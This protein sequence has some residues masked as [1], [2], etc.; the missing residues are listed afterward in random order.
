[1]GLVVVVEEGI[2][3]VSGGGDGGDGEGVVVVMELLVM[4]GG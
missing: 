3:F 1:M 4:C 2:V